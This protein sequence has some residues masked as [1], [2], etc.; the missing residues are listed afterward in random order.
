M[1]TYQMAGVDIDVADCFTQMIR[2]RVEKAWPKGGK[3]IGRFAGRGEI[4]L[5]A[6]RVNASCDG[7]GTKIIL[8]AILEMFEGIGQDAVAMSVVDTYVSGS[9]P[10]YLLD[11]LNVGKLN[12]DVH[13][14][15]IESVI[16]GCLKAGCR[17]IG[18]ETAELPGMFKY[19]WMINLDTFVVGFPNP[20]MAFIPLESGQRVYGWPSYGPASNGF[21]LLREIFGLTL[22][23]G[24]L[25][26]IR[27]SLG[28]EGSLKKERQSLGRHWSEL[29]STLAQA[30]LEPTP[31]WIQQIEEAR[32]NGAKFAGHAHITGGG[33][34]GNIPRILTSNTKVKVV[35]ER[36]EWPRPRIFRLVQE[37]GKVSPEE[38]DR[39]F[40]QGVMLI[41]ITAKDGKELNRPAMLIGEV[42]RRKR[43]EPQLVL[44]GQYRDE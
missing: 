36:S 7:T 1:T 8:A 19:P 18:G 2:E 14:K 29:G 3:E 28:M 20:D 43:D 32:R 31:I 11:V 42:Q 6:K 30:L 34:P 13:I 27:E 40:N 37:V 10:L 33:M 4:P 25:Q 44:T 12:P 35:I 41:S 23:E 38:M 22:K 5:G 39:T 26:P 9:L 15:I 21:S 16:Q 24:L 17:L